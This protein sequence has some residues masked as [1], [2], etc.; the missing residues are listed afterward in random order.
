MFLKV[1]C[2]DSPCHE[3]KSE[4]TFVELELELELEPL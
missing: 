1:Q 2:I 4:C 3:L